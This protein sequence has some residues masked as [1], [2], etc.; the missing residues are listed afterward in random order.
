MSTNSDILGAKALEICSE[1]GG[2]I[3]DL[4]VEFVVSTLMTSG[5]NP[6][7]VDGMLFA[8]RLERQMLAAGQALT[9]DAPAC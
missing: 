3:E 2:C 6:L 8:S 7:H 4:V 1:S 5:D 9:R